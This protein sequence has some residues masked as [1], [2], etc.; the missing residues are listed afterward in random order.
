MIAPDPSPAPPSPGPPPA[1]HGI[2]VDLVEIARVAAIHERFGARFAERVLG[3][4]ERAALAAERR[5]ARFLA[6]RFA[7]KEAFVKA[8]GTG[9]RHGIALHEIEVHKDPEGRPSLTLS[10]CAAKEAAR[11]G[12]GPAHLSLSDEAGHALAFVVLERR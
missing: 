9:F 8:L 6:M 5:P 10:G 3:P 11:R 2:G 12:A 7:A 1:L 4:L